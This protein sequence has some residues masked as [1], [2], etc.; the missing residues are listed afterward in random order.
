MTKPDRGYAKRTG[1]RGEEEAVQYL[2]RKGFQILE[3]KWRYG[4][5]EIDIIARDGAVLVFVE[6]KT[7]KAEGFGEPEDW[8]SRRKQNQIGRLA[9]GYL[10]VRS[11]ENE[12]CRF[13]VVTV[14]LTTGRPSVNH[15]EDA[16]WIDSKASWRLF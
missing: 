1:D 2:E 12:E 5:G 8:I 7:K 13:D 15:I 3:R 4:Q 14:D 16:F 11:I 9:A 10:Q 6:V